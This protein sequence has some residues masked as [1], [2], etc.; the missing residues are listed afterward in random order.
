MH[1][2]V[3]R[4]SYASA[5][6]PSQQ[7][8]AVLIYKAL[9]LAGSFSIR[10][11]LCLILRGFKPGGSICIKANHGQMVRVWIKRIRFRL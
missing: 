9:F 11:C 7:H 1:V 5:L 4:E 10:S 2:K 3:G 6:L 8:H